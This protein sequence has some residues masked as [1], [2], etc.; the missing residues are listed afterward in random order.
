MLLNGGVLFGEAGSVILT[1][2]LSAVKIEML[3]G[4]MQG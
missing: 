1:M 3:L 4:E 2:G